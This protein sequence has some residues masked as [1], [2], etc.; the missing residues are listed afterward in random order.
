MKIRHIAALLAAA[1]L[2]TATAAVA[3]D[4]NGSIDWAGGFVLATGHGT[5]DP[6]INKAKARNMAMRAAEVSAQRALLETIKGVHITSMTTVENSMLTEDVIKSRVDGV[7]KGAIIVK[8][9]VE[10]VDG[11]PLATVIMKICLNGGPAE[12]ASKPTLVNVLSL[13]NRPLPGH[14]PAKTLAEANIPAP[15]CP[16]PGTPAADQSQAPPQEAAPGA[17]PVPA[18]APASEPV[19]A[20]APSSYKPPQYDSTKPVT[21][22]VFNLDGRYYERELLPVVITTASGEA[23]TVYSVKNINPSVV[24]TYGAVRYA[25]N[26]DLARQNQTVGANPLVI[27]VDDITRE[28]MIRIKSNDA[29]LLKENCS[30][31]N[32]LLSEAKVVISK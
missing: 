20:A 8:R 18:V 26:L 23:V 17:A 6:K 2:A 12:C 13:D 7:V 14:V 10:E 11:A 1:L 32:N 21:G 3:E 27:T 31:G 4:A 28:N 22:I 24:R 5:A 19:A 16:T 30:H 29:R 15:D 25:E 9:D